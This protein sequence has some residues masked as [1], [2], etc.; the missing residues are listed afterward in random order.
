MKTFRKFLLVPSLLL[1]GLTVSGDTPETGTPL[2]PAQIRSSKGGSAFYR[3]GA[4]HLRI[5]DPYADPAV[6]LLPPKEQKFFDLSHGRNFAVDVTNLSKKRQGRF[7]IFLKT[8]D[9]TESRRNPDVALCVT[10]PLALSGTG[11]TARCADDRH[12]QNHFD[13]L[14]V[15]R[16]V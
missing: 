4:L 3:D 7:L 2:P 9:R 6:S 13:R 10:A 5:D 12:F 11:R 15:A 1:A 16:L 8:P 14:C